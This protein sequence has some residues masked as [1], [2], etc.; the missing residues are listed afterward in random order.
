[1]PDTRGRG[2]GSC[3]ESLAVVLRRKQKPSED[4]VQTWRAG[5][6]ERCLSGSERGSWKRGLMVHV[7]SRANYL[8]YTVRRRFESS[9]PHFNLQYKQQHLQMTSTVCGITLPSGLNA[10]NRDYKAT[11]CGQAGQGMKCVP[12][13]RQKAI[14]VCC[15]CCVSQWALRP[16]AMLKAV[17]SILPVS[18]W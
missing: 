17:S 3:T 2:T 10:H 4:E 14:V 1:M 8:L 12:L 7:R 11:L 5:C 18:I 9:Q 16:F 13:R 6:I 15:C